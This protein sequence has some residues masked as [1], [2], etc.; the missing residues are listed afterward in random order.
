MGLS[1]T[2]RMYITKRKTNKY[3]GYILVI[4][5]FILDDSSLNYKQV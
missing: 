4:P 1:D 5:Y 2:Q 3:L